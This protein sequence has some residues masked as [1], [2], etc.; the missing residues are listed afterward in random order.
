MGDCADEIDDWDDG[1]FRDNANGF[2]SGEVCP[3]GLVTDGSYQTA[4]QELAINEGDG[5]SNDYDHCV[6]LNECNIDLLHVATVVIV[7]LLNENTNV[8]GI[9]VTK[10]QTTEGSYTCELT[11]RKEVVYFS[12]GI[13]TKLLKS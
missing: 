13:T 10:L 8:C 2:S 7:L 1:Y 12:V 6:D 9:M 3:V 4:D 5:G 11:F